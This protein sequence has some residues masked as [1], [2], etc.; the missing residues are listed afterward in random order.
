M[1]EPDET[2]CTEEA[3]LRITNLGQICSDKR[4]NQMKPWGEIRNRA[5]RISE[6]VLSLVFSGVG[7]SNPLSPTILH[8][9]FAIQKSFLAVGTQSVP[10]EAFA[11][12]SAASNILSYSRYSAYLPSRTPRHRAARSRKFRRLQ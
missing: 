1:L 7:G 4:R 3:K 9:L 10:I 8:F 11:L 12:E 2:G 6:I 5:K